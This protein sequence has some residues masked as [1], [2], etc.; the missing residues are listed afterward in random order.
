VSFNDVG[1]GAAEPTIGVNANNVAFFAAS[2]FDFPTPTFPVRLARTLV[3][4]S[5]PSA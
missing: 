3:M 5:L 2:T 4:R 1:R